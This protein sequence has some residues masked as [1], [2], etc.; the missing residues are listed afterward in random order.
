[1]QAAANRPADSHCAQPWSSQKH[2][3]TRGIAAMRESVSRLGR[4]SIG[5]LFLAAAPEVVMDFLGDRFGDA[6]HRLDVLDRGDRDRPGTAEMVQQG[7]FATGTDAGDLVEG[8]ACE[9]GGAAGAMRAD[10]E[11][12]GLVTQALQEVEHRVARLERE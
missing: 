9:V 11:A 5:A 12:M 3:T 10:G 1:M 4:L 6:R 7:T 2:A 8:G